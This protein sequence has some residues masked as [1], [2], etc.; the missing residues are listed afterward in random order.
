MSLTALCTA[1]PALQCQQ[2]VIPSVLYLSHVYALQLPAI[3]LQF[4][5]A[6]SLSAAEDGSMDAVVS[7][8]GLSLMGTDYGSLLKHIECC[9]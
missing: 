6:S 1:M 2:P 9:M 8:Q 3:E 7:T 5:V 4:V